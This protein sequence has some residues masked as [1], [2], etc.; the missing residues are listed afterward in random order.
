MKFLLEA[1]LA[2][3]QGKKNRAYEKYT[4]SIALAVD[5]GFRMIEAMSHEHAGRHLFATG[6]EVLA[7]A[8]FRKALDCYEQWGAR[9]K[10]EHLEAEVR[11]TFSL[12][13]VR[14]DEPERTASHRF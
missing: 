11:D 10:Y 7:A 5:A 6:D 4:A 1:E 12:T 3:F 9:A 8:S 2:S 14:F 13:S